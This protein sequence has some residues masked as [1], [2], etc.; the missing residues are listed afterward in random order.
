MMK[1]RSVK[2]MY[3]ISATIGTMAAKRFASILGPLERTHQRGE[4]AY[5]VMEGVREF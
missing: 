1:G 4:D 2:V 5:V 3:L